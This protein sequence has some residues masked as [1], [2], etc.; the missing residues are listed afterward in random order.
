MCGSIA[1]ITDL[2]DWK[3][4]EIVD[5]AHK[6]HQAVRSEWRLKAKTID[7]INRKHLQERIDQGKLK[8][9]DIRDQPRPD[10]TT[11]LVIDNTAYISSSMRGG[12]FLYRP[13]PVWTPSNE[14]R[15]VAVLRNNLVCRKEVVSALTACQTKARAKG[16]LSGHRTGASCGEPMA[17][18]AFSTTTTQKNIEESGARIVS[19]KDKSLGSETS[20]IVPPCGGDLDDPKPSKSE[21]SVFR[22][23]S[24]AQAV[25]WLTSAIEIYSRVGM[26]STGEGTQCQGDRERQEHRERGQPC[27][28][29]CRGPLC[30]SMSKSIELVA[31]YLCEVVGLGWDMFILF[32]PDDLAEDV[33]HLEHLGA[34]GGLWGPLD[35]ARDVPSASAKEKG[36]DDHVCGVIR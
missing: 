29:F 2:A 11:V 36:L 6:A 21:V 25:I 3:D 5:L 34:K 15:H 23:I 17:M 10:V 24:M 20:K 26:R 19:V 27:G 7:R 13:K 1:T 4:E 35:S 33:Q 31:W 22:Y 18:L 9:E 28:V 30:V 14:P 8:L 32:S 16:K 12:S